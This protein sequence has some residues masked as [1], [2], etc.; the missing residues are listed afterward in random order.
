MSIPITQFIPSPFLVT[1]SLFSTS[2]TLFLLCKYGH[3]CLFFFFFRFHRSA[4]TNG[5]CLCLTYFTQ[6]SEGHSG[7]LG[8]F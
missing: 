6:V 1:I 3:L 5:V 8:R 7:I 4:I 2:V